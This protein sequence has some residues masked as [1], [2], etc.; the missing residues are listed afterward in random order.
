[1][2]GAAAG[3]LLGTSAGAYVGG[4]G[5]PRTGTFTPLGSGAIAGGERGTMTGAILGWHIGGS[6]GSLIDRLGCPHRVLEP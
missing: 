4:S 2:V 5:Q 3:G 1:M 6:I